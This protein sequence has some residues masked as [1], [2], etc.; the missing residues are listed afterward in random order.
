[1]TRKAE[2]EEE[3]DFPVLW[4]GVSDFF[5]SKLYVPKS[6]RGIQAVKEPF[7]LPLRISCPRWE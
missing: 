3:R 7:P 1:M 2:P 5:K 4:K 6:K